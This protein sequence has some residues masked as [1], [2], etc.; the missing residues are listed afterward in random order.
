MVQDSPSS[1]PAARST[2]LLSRA[3]DQHPTTAR[4]SPASS[5]W[6]RQFGTCPAAGSRGYA[7]LPERDFPGSLD[8][9]FYAMGVYAAK[10][11]TITFHKGSFV[12]RGRIAKRPTEAEGVS[13]ALPPGP[14]FRT[15]ESM[16][17]L[18]PEEIVRLTP[19]ERLALIAQ[20]WDSLE[21]EQLPLTSAQEAEL[22]RRL[23]SL[24]EDRRN[25]VTWA[26]LKTELEQR[27]P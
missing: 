17:L 12:Q 18:T 2:S 13:A 23:S 9:H 26:S 6:I 3:P 27:C 15:L 24:D 19:L 11:V 4:N 22:E 1:P 16:E 10:W 20:L 5:A 8:A 14:L 7:D 25:G 21:H